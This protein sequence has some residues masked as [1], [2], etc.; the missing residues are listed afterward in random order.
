MYRPIVSFLMIDYKIFVNNGNEAFGTTGKTL[1][2]EEQ[3]RTISEDFLAEEMHHANELIPKRT[4]K[5]VLSIFSEVSARLMA[6]GFAIQ[7]Q[8]DGKV[9]HRQRL[10]LRQGHRSQGREPAARFHHHPHRIQHNG[11]QGQVQL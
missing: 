6:E 3:P 5:E 2:V 9:P 10:R 1:S 11:D 4:I 7:F 8:K